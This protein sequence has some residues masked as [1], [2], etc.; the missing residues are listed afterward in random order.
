M[1]K[2]TLTA[3]RLRFL[4]LYDP[5]TGIFT[6]KNKSNRHHVIGE[7][8]GSPHNLGYIQIGVDGNNYLAHRLAWLYMV[9]TWPS[10]QVDHRDLDK[11]NN[12]WSNLR[13]AT[14]VQQSWNVAVRSSNVSGLKGVSFDKRR[15]RY[16]AYI[17]RSGARSFLGSR[18]SAEEAH[19]LYRSAV[20][21]ER[22]DFG[23]CR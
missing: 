12:A 18:F 7:K 5:K 20:L 16:V 21:K 8:C 19:E 11:K 14:A 3:G 6:R 9:G 22:G 15:G 10:C 4:L 1:S 17:T 23:R 13:E 2:S